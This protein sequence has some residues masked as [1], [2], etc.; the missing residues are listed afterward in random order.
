MFQDFKDAHRVGLNIRAIGKKVS[1]WDPDGTMQLETFKKWVE[2]HGDADAI[3]QH[4]SKSMGVVVAWSKEVLAAA[5]LF[6]TE[7]ETRVLEA[8]FYVG[9]E[10]CL[11][12]D[13]GAEFEC[14]LNTERLPYIFNNQVT[15]TNIEAKMAWINEKVSLTL[16]IR[17]V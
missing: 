16:I 12:L 10:A 5:P 7:E 3:E 6:V 13:V 15:L 14:P 17:A 4:L 11:P 8:I 9:L 2:E 1:K